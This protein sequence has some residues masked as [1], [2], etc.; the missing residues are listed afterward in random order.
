MSTFTRSMILIVLA[1]VLNIAVGEAQA[2]CE[3]VTGNGRCNSSNSFLVTMPTTNTDGTGFNDYAST[4]ILFS[5][6]PGVCAA[7]VGV[8][9]RNLGPLGV[10]VTPIPN[11]V[12]KTLMGPLALPNA[13][14]FAAAR[15]V[16]LVGN[17]SACSP[18]I[19]FT[20][21]NVA[22]SAPGLSVGP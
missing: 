14:V 8:T 3:G 7:T 4:E 16:D 1:L 18:E 21:D 13:K 2:V 9:V 20:N 22:A 5:Q 11:T 6:A 19:S 15:V 12:A 17:R 10:P